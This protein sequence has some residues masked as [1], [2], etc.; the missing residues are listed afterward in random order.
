MSRLSLPI[1]L[2][3]WLLLLGVPV[4]MA[5]TPSSSTQR[6]TPNFQNVDITVLAEAVG[7]A[8]GI[9]FI[10]DPRV[11]A[12]VSLINPRP[13]TST[14][15]YHAFLSILQV[16]N[17]AA[18]RSG[19]VVKIVPDANV[20]T[21][22]GNDL[23]ANLNSGSD[24]MVTT[25]I[26]AK[27]I[28]ANQ[29]SAVLRPLVAQYGNLAPVPGTNSLIITDRASNVSRI[30]RIVNRVDQAS[31][32]NVEVIPLQHSTAADVVRTLSALTGGAGAAADP[33]GGLAPRMVA[34]D[35][36]NSIL[37]S[38]DPSQRLRISTWIAH[39]DTPL[40]NGGDTQ[41]RYLRYADAEKIAP[42]LKEQLTGLVAASGGSPAGGAA[43][44]IER[45]VIIGAEPETNALIITAPPK[46]MRSLMT[47]IDKL[48]IRRAQVHIEAI[49]AEI[50]NGKSADLGVNWALF[51][52]ENGQN[53][54]AGG[55]VSPIGGSSIVNLIGAAANPTAAITAGAIPR[56]TTFAVGR[57]RDSGINFG[58]VL[59]AIRE[60]T[61][62]NVVATPSITTMDNL[63]AKI[64]IA[65]EVPFITGQFTNTGTTN[66][67]QVNPFT[68]VQRQKVGTILTVTPQING[69][70]AIMLTI[71]L[72]SSELSA[73][74]GD[75]GSRI[76][77]TRTF[78][79]TVLVEDGATIVVGGLIRDAEVGSQQRVPF[80]SRIPLIGEAFKV[81]SKTRDKSNLMVFIRP[82]ILTDGVQSTIETNA[83]YNTFR[84]A[85]IQ[86]GDT[87]ELLPLLPFD[88]SPRLPPLAPPPAPATGESAAPK[89]EPKSAP[90]AP[91]PVAPAATPEAKS[92]AK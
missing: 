92:E 46:Q 64:E 59:R 67:G 30:Q 58:A 51:S 66:N 33:A 78:K 82:R 32:S 28:S 72:E 52:N 42:K 36:S 24:E 56:G 22:P 9:T 70:D 15:L 25:V 16:H 18:V 26:E 69:G 85:Q 90:A 6:I 43:A 12:Q 20:R 65:S 62:N 38:G 81:R 34:D 31:N 76:V 75:A 2:A 63:E 45:N 35:R 39:L 68:T 5:Q 47:I 55:F 4:V 10:P 7:A 49:I 84:D 13:M 80:L 37:L 50:K 29:L 1:Q 27:N 73:A 61:N 8:T 17:F 48:D 71:A 23:P 11:R 21:M 74:L 60:D 41:V 87:R 44:S 19:N 83:K 91:A 86:Q 53:I 57:L 79:N 3:P 88:R 40:E 89:T 77:D 14:E 54:P